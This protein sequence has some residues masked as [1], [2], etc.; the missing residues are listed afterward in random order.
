MADTRALFTHRFEAARAAWTQGDEPTAAESFHSAIIAARSDPNLRGEL[1]IALVHLGKLSR[2]LGPAGEAE[3]EQ[4]L[5]EALAICERLFGSEHPAL[6]PVLHELSRLHIQRSQYARAED[7][8]ERLLAIARHKGEEHPDVAA[9]LSDLAFVKH[10]FGDEASAEALY[11]EA[12]RIRE[13]VLEPNHMATVGTLER[14]SETCAAR[15]NFAEALALLRRA[16]PSREAAL[17]AGHERVR[18]ARSRVAQLES[19]M[20]IA[21]DTAAAASATREAKPTPTWLTRGPDRPTI[22]GPSPINSNEEDVARDAAPGVWRA[23]VAVVDAVWPEPARKESRVYAAGVAA[24]VIAIAALLMVRPGTGTGRDPDSTKMSAEQR[25]TAAGTIVVTATRNGSIGTRGEA[26]V[27]S[28]RAGASATP[29]RTAPGRGSQREQS[30]PERARPDLR[31]PSVEVQLD[32]ETLPNTPAARRLDSI[33]HS[34]VERQRASD[35]I[36]TDPR[37]GISRR[38]SAAVYYA[39]TSPRIIGSAPDLAFPTALLRAGLREGQVDVRFMVNEHGRVDLAS[40]VVERSDH[41]LF[42][43]AVRDAV[44]R[45]RFEPA[46]TLGPESKPFAAWVSLPFRF[47]TKN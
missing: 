35:T 27:V 18:A 30:A 19:Q 29:A 2:K 39:H 15:G 3:A 11:R 44:R 7:A 46:R 13:K 25:S 28:A 12:L 22:H 32:S 24:V 4:L 6:A 40:I 45:L 34:A 47:T 26:I 43:A 17:G 20:A 9:A 8:L 14:L 31:L 36:W 1:A 42:T 37:E 41:E 10:K 23:A 16:I 21:A 5:T 38:M 33:L